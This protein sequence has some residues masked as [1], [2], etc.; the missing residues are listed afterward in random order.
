MRH[1]VYEITQC[2]DWIKAS[3]FA[4]IQLR[5]SSKGSSAHNSDCGEDQGLAKK[6]LVH[7]EF[8]DRWA[9][10]FSNRVPNLLS[11]NFDEEVLVRVDWRWVLNAWWRKV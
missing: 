11:V 6:V 10:T 9:F 1:E 8:N 7:G 2:I 3:V 4:L 5:R